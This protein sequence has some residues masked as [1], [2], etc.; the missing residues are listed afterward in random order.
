M[1]TGG[2][3]DLGGI[4]K[5]LSPTFVQFASRSSLSCAL[6]DQMSRTATSEVPTHPVKSISINRGHFCTST[7]TLAPVIWS[8]SHNLILRSKGHDSDMAMTPTSVIFLQPSRLMPCI[9]GE[10]AA[11]MRI[12]PRLPS[13]AY[14][15]GWRGKRRWLD[16]P[17]E[18][19]SFHAFQTAEMGILDLVCHI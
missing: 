2:D 16:A 8:N 5:A 18:G 1:L 17:C 10:D 12:G 4:G 9:L 3:E 7:E 14:W 19:Q 11:T 15:R 6:F 13:C